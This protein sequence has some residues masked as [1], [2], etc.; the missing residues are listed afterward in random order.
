MKTGLLFD[1]PKTGPSIQTRINE[2]KK[3]HHIKTHRSDA[4]PEAP[5]IALLPTDEDK[6]REIFDIMADSCRLYDEA[7]MLVES[8]GELSAIRKLCE[9]NSIDCNL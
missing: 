2:F 1:L 5:W 6:D 3:L 4:C 9:M 8:T 7:K